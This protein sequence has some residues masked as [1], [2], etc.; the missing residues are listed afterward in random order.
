MEHLGESVS[1]KE[2]LV[3]LDPFS[4]HQVLRLIYF[5][6]WWKCDPN[7][8]FLV[9]ESAWLKKAGILPLHRW[10]SSWLL[11]WGT[12]ETYHLWFIFVKRECM[13]DFR[14]CNDSLLFTWRFEVSHRQ[15]PT[16]K[17]NITRLKKFRHSTAV[18]SPSTIKHFGQRKFQAETYIKTAHP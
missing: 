1:E 16:S 6:Q 14:R 2:I 8:K 12:W 11:G 9:K 5:E 7:N 17:N 13:K 10:M 3:I 4:G 15:C 18:R